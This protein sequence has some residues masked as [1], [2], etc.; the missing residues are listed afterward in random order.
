MLQPII[1]IILRCLILKPIQLNNYGKTLQNFVMW[2][3]GFLKQK[4]SV[5]TIG[6]NLVRNLFHNNPVTY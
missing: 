5:K 3:S 4:I 2:I 1:I 6:E